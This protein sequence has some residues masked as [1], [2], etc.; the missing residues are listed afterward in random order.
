MQL[1]HDPAHG[2][3]AGLHVA[4]LGATLCTIDGEG[5]VV[6]TTV[7]LPAGLDGGVSVPVEASVTNAM[8][9][10]LYESKAMVTLVY[11]ARRAQL[12]AS[13]PRGRGAVHALTWA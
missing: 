8:G 4:R 12:R 5:T 2:H 13:L 10:S 9:T 11:I 3:G 1:V 6:L 7:P